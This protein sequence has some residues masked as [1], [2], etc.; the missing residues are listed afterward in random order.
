MEL[1][2]VIGWFWP[3]P[4]VFPILLT[5]TFVESL[6]FYICRKGFL[7]VGHKRALG[8]SLEAGDF[9]IVYI[10]EQVPES[11]LTVIELM[12]WVSTSSEN[13]KPGQICQRQ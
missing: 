4:T 5:A 8:D 11:T 6:L 13:A 12:S 7:L 1:Q 10:I 9:G 3:V 2:A